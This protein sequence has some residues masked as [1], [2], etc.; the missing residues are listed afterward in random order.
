[1][2]ADHG[3][4]PPETPSQF[5]GVLFTWTVVALSGVVPL[6]LIKSTPKPPDAVA[7]TL[8]LVVL[9]WSGAHLAWLIGVGRP[10]LPEFS[11][12]V[13]LYAFMGLAPIVQLRLQEFPTTTPGVSQ[14][15]TGRAAWV[16]VL[17]MACV[18]LG[19]FAS[20]RVRP[21]R[22]SAPA[23]I[24]QRRAVLL[25]LVGSVLATYYISRVGIGTLWST[26]FQLDQRKGELWSDTTTAAIVSVLAYVPLL[27]ASHGLVRNRRLARAAGQKAT[28]GPLLAL[29]LLLLFTVINPVTSPRY[30]VGTV[31]LSFLFLLGGFKTP[32]RTRLALALITVLLTVVFPYADVFRTEAGGSNQQTVL[33]NLALNGDYDAFTQTVNAMTYV[34][35][36]GV[37]DG[38]Q[39]LGVVLFWV[40]R[41]LW[42]GKPLDSGILLAEDQGYKFTNL[43]SPIWAEMYINAGWLGVMIGSVL[44]G[45][46]IGRLGAHLHQHDRNNTAESVILGILS[47]YLLI[48]LRGSLL[49]AMANLTVLVACGLFIRRRRTT[50]EGHSPADATVIRTVS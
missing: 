37:T 40:P 22:P 49:Q 35:R 50:P 9:L 21:L 46:V 12:W 7:W 45:F 48:V 19:L 43:S 20:R 23:G 18:E 26:R 30:I 27:V 39:A 33:Q 4:D 10:R 5:S 6:V 1:M 36:H 44:L 24:S 14:Q 34:A 15:M 31:I 38:Y 3:I 11:L 29:C 13:F 41:S 28:T 25:A 32:T 8:C 2:A 16:I 47:F 42:P 17:G